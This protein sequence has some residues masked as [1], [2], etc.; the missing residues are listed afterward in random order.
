MRAPGPRGCQMFVFLLDA[1][2]V[3]LR[4]ALATSYTVIID[5]RVTLGGPPSDTSLSSPHL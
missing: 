3:K 2:C 5:G 1:Y 4:C